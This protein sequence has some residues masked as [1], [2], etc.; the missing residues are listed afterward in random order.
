[1]EDNVDFITHR[2]LE[3]MLR[4]EKSYDKLVKASRTN[5]GNISFEL[6]NVISS[7]GISTS[8]RNINVILELVRQSVQQ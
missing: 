2:L 7:Y 4:D 5:N 3:L 1:M 6:K 8:P